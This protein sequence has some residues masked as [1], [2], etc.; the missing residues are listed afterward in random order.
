MCTERHW[1]RSCAQNAMG[2]AHV[3]QSDTAGQSLESL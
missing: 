3:P 1:E 2:G